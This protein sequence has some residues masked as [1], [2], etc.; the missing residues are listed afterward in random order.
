MYTF[1]DLVVSF[2]VG[3]LVTLILTSI[4]LDNSRLKEARLEAD[5]ALEDLKEYEVHEHYTKDIE[6]PVPLYFCTTCYLTKNFKGSV[7]HQP[8]YESDLME[9]TCELCGK[10][11][12]V[13]YILA[14]RR[15]A[16]MARE[17]YK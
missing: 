6:D 13:F 5:K 14:D 11:D 9:F 2:L 7:I 3:V 15:T 4:S 17:V 16:Q 8:V 12:S 1:N 10:N